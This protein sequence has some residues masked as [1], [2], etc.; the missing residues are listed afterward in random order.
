[1]GVTLAAAGEILL[2]LA[3][4]NSVLRFV[5]SALFDREDAEARLLAVASSVIS[6]VAVCVLYSG[7]FSRHLIEAVDVWVGAGELTDDV[8]NAA[9]RFDELATSLGNALSPGPTLEYRPSPTLIPLAIITAFYLV[10]WTIYATVSRKKLRYAS[11]TGSVYWTHISAY[12]MAVSFVVVLVNWNLVAVVLGSALA[13]V[14]LLFG[15][16][17]FFADVGYAL[18]GLATLTWR[19]VT[20]VGEVLARASVRVARFVRL[21]F[22]RA[23]TFYIAYVRKPVRAS[24][25]WAVEG[26]RRLDL[27]AK[28]KLREENQRNEELFS[29]AH[30]GDTTAPP[31]PD[32]NPPGLEPMS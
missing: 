19:L 18:R 27:R 31:E 3:L 11:V 14:V 5:H 21:A 10:R 29:K 17:G 15:M 2:V 22:R 13:L 25:D 6:L 28:E 23:H 8:A 4:A 20:T 32:A 9:H 30:R 7:M 24:T 16:A 1:V 26:S 12:A